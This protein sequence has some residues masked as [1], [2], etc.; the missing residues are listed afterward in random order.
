MKWVRS[1]S[2]HQ[3]VLAITWIY[4]HARMAVRLGRVAL[5]A[6]FEENPLRYGYFMW[7][8]DHYCSVCVQLLC[9]RQGTAPSQHQF[10][11]VLL[12]HSFACFTPQKHQPSILDPLHTNGPPRTL[13]APGSLAEALLLSCWFPD[14][15]GEGGGSHYLSIFCSRWK[16]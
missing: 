12:G 8:H 3:A 14:A 4:N 5:C 16:L 9:L 11:L 6:H 7:L 13:M 10:W 15:M 1:T 2:G